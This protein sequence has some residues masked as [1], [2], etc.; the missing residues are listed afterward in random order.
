MS[1]S[2]KNPQFA[3]QY[4]TNAADINTNWY[5][6]SVNLESLSSLIP[7]TAKTFLDFGCGPGDFTF[8]LKESGHDIDGCD[9]S[10]AMVELA[11]QHFKGINFFIWDGNDKCPTDKYYDVVISKLTLHSV[12]D[13]DNLAVRL[14]EVLNQKGS[15]LI[16]VPHPIPTIPKAHGAYLKKVHYDTEIGSY[17]IQV[18]M[19]HRSLQDYITPFLGNG[20]VLT[21]IIEPTIPDELIKKYAVK[22]E[23]AQVP[24]RLNLRFQKAV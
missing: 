23:Y 2:W 10:P 4:M 13:L 21:G 3:E 15:L 16:S 8:Q 14:A 19:I 12:E 5:E 20:F 1:D 9:G 11:Q 24:R 7:T 22:E 17:G 6:H 18:T